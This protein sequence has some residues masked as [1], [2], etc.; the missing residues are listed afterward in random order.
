MPPC[1]A[2]NQAL[3]AAKGRE[4]ATRQ[5]IAANEAQFNSLQ[6][7][8]AQ[9]AAQERQLA[10]QAAALGQQAGALTQQAA[11]L[12]Q[13][14]NALAAKGA[15]L[16]AQ[17]NTLAGQGTSLQAQANALAGQGASLQ[18]QGD[19]LQAQGNS[20]QA[21]GRLAAGS[22]ARASKPSS[23]R[24][25]N[26]QKQAMALQQQLT[27]ELTYAG[28][29]A[30]GTDPRLVKLE[31]ALYTPS[32]VLK[33]SPPTINKK[34]NAATFSVIP[35]TRP[36]ATATANLVTQLRTSVIPPADPYLRP[37]QHRGRRRRGLGQPGHAGQQGLLAAIQPL[38]HHRLRGRG[39]GRQR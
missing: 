33:V 17:A 16:Q 25:E 5:Q 9:L 12:Q 28:G 8:A 24:R 19:S 13:Q 7:Q 11:G 23:S 4:T 32:G 15:S 21:P 39:H 30:R 22:R 38:Q 2:L 3:A 1:P 36:A 35:T 34:G 26:E 37:A 20:L 6:Q 29:D 14:A 10:G 18:Q 31:N 27:D